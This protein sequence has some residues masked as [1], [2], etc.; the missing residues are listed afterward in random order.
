MLQDTQLLLP[1]CLEASVTRS[2][3][4]RSTL[5]RSILLVLAALGFFLTTTAL[6]CSGSGQD[7]DRSSD[8]V[9]V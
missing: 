7:P 3:F 9:G 8:M 4:R 1:T 6:G 5:R 2:T